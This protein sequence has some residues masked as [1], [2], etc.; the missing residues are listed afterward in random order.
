MIKTCPNCH[1]EFDPVR[2][3]EFPSRF[4]YVKDA[5]FCDNCIDDRIRHNI[6]ENLIG[7]EIHN[8]TS[9]NIFK[10]MPYYMA[11]SDRFE[12][13]SWFFR[14]ASKFNLMSHSVFNRIGTASPYP[15]ITGKVLNYIS[16][17]HLTEFFDFLINCWDNYSESEKESILSSIEPIAKQFITYKDDKKLRIKLD[18]IATI[19]G[20]LFNDAFTISE[21]SGK[22]LDVLISTIKNNSNLD[23]WYNFAAKHKKGNLVQL[24]KSLIYIENFKPISSHQSSSPIIALC[25]FLLIPYEKLIECN[26]ADHDLRMFINW[27]LENSENRYLP[28]GENNFSAISLEE[29]NEFY[30]FYIN[31][32]AELSAKEEGLKQKESSIL[33]QITKKKEQIDIINKEIDQ[34]NLL[35]WH[36]NES[37]ERIYILQSLLDLNPVEKLEF[38]SKY[39]KPLQYFPEHLINLDEKYV[40]K[41]DTETIS[42]LKNKLKFVKKGYYKKLA[43]LIDS[44]EPSKSKNK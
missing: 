27:I 24:I 15:F 38:V 40:R 25:K 30:S 9:D 32:D 36:K 11:L 8:P 34:K 35:I 2:W 20:K 23:A 4:S 41:L 13:Y 33:E 37:L 42:A 26:E 14:E 44:L 3:R 22:E 12:F 31:S 10:M 16:E 1:L 7:Y 5:R 18:S 43:K 6:L 28:L 17:K 39:E 19:F 21:L 29:Y